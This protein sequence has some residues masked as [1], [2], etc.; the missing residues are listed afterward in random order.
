MTNAGLAVILIAVLF[1]P[2]M[3][4]QIEHNIEVFFLIAGLAAAAISG[5][6]DTD[7]RHQ[8]ASEPVAFSAAV[9][10]FGVAFRVAQAPLDRLFARLVAVMAPRW[11]CLGLIVVLGGLASIITAV[12]AALVLAEAI[13]MLH[14]ERR[15][16]IRVTVLACFAIGLGAVL[17]PIGEPLSAIAVSNLKADFW[18]LARLIGPEILAGVAIVAALCLIP[19]AESGARREAVVAAEPWMTIVMRAVKVFVFVAGLVALAAGFRPLADTYL[20]RLPDAALY[21]MN[22]ISAVVDNATLAAAEISP[23]L[24]PHQ[25]REI[26]MSLLISGGM[27]IPGN[28]PNIVAATRLRITGREWAKLG[29]PIGLPLMAACFVVLKGC[30]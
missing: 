8:A 27:L 23:A 25:Q 9:L 13:A 30:Y 12:I 14:L 24:T 28:I 11:I 16:E 3:V 26:L 19:G 6:I 2:V 5:K 22:S 10:V 20:S 7:L 17:T 1:G 15:S 29:L 21:W 4:E 18:Y